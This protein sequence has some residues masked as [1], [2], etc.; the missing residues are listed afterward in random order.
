MSQHQ[1]QHH[2]RESGTQGR[3]P[4]QPQCI[5]STRG[6]ASP[7]ANQRMAAL[8]SPVGCWAVLLVSSTAALAWC[9]RFGSCPAPP[10][11]RLA[12]QREGGWAAPPPVETMEP[13]PAGEQGEPNLWVSTTRF[14]PLPVFVRGRSRPCERPDQAREGRRPPQQLVLRSSPQS[15]PGRLSI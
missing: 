3:A 14:S 6:C 1:P 12:E 4:M 15:R 11:H 9:T 10:F 8:A 13:A 5:C 7:A 2:A